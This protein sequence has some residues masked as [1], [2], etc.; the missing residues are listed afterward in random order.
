MNGY[1]LVSA[2]LG[3]GAFLYCSASG[4]QAETKLIY[5]VLWRGCE[6]ACQGFQDYLS[7]AGVDSE[8]VVRDAGQDKALLP[9]FLEEA[10]EMKVDLIFTWGTSA[11]LGIAG[12]LEDVGDPRFNNAILQVF[13]VVADPVGAGIVESLEKTGRA[14]ITGT[15]NRVPETVNINAIRSYDPAFRRLGLLYNANEP[16]SLLKRDEMAALTREFGF[17]LV[18]VEL[19]LGDDG[20]PRV[21]DIPVKVAELK[22]KGVDF[23]YVGSSSFLDK[24]RDVFTGAAVDL[25]LPVLSP[26]ERLVRESQALFSVAAR[27]YDVGR[28]AGAQAKKILVDGMAP[29]DIPV[30]RMTDFAYVVNMEIA[31]KLNLYPPVEI[32]QFA[33]T[34]N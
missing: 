10:R 1:S 17:E 5:G 14:N 4:A 7:E 26:Y 31:R 11:T 20:K 9:V 16:N 22:E 18:A 30:A 32:L 15:F 29:G 2:F 25:G 13:T 3:L 8:F 19:E 34:V 27:Y 12:T 24:N 23:I 21:E 28:L 6:E 33:E